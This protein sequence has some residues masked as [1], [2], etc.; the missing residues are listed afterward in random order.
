MISGCPKDLAD[1]DTIETIR[2]AKL[3]LK[4]LPPVDGGALD[5]SA[6]FLAAAEFVADE[7]QFWKNKLG[8][9]DLA[10]VSMM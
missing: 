2:L 9:N 6:C 1:R 3:Y 4:G 8:I 7:M 5:Q 10:W